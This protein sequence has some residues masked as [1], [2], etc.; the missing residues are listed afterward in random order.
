MGRARGTVHRV[1]AAKQRGS[2]LGGCHDSRNT[3]NKQVSGDVN[4]MRCNTPTK[5]HTH[6]ISQPTYGSTRRLRMPC[7]PLGSTC[8]HCPGMCRP[9]MR[10]S[11]LQSTQNPQDNPG[12]G[13][14]VEHGPDR[15]TSHGTRNLRDTGDGGAQRRARHATPAMN[16]SF[17]NHVLRWAAVYYIRCTEIPRWHCGWAR[18]TRRTID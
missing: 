7:S 11:S 13:S 18:C 10:F 17:T 5:Q 2:R 9:G 12:S 1:V 4:F 3:P 14:G 8:A 6:V 16:D 15:M